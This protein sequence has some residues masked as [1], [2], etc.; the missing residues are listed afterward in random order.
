MKEREKINVSLSFCSLLQAIT[1]LTQQHTSY[2]NFDT[3]RTRFFLSTALHCTS[4]WGRGGTAM[5][6]AGDYEML[7]GKVCSCPFHCVNSPLPSQQQWGRKSNLISSTA[8]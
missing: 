4:W 2:D 6:I 8:V 5:R 1:Q 7:I 3:R